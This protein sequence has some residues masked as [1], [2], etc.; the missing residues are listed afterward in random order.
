M[1]QAVLITTI[2]HGL[3]E[4]SEMAT[5]GN[6]R[7]LIKSQALEMR[8]ECREMVGGILDALRSIVASV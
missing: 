8:K 5:I 7:V 1:P 4:E 6:G 2:P 3:S